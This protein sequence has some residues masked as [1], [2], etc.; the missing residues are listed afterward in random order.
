MKRQLA[1]IQRITNISPIEGANLIVQ[2]QVLG[3]SC[4]AKKSEFEIGDLCIYFEIDS[5]LPE[6]DEFKFLGKSCWNTPLQRY[7]IKTCRIRGFVSQGLVLPLKMFER[8]FPIDFKL[9]EGTDV[10][11]LFGVEK[12]DD[13]VTYQQGE[14]DPGFVWPISKTDEIRIQAKPQM[15]DELVGKP[16]YITC[17]MDGTSAT[18]IFKGIGED[19]RFYV[20]SRNHRII[21]DPGSIYWAV[22]KQYKIAEVLERHYDATGE[23]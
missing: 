21:E 8:L 5:L 16:Y 2:I 1:S 4:V 19:K 15:F 12:Y 13:A 22:A 23:S 17:K 9:E 14:N 3:W 10:T 11:D 20:C 18:Y 6:M 7:H